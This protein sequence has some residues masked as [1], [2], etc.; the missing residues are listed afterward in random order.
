MALLMKY[1]FALNLAVIIL[2]FCV[3]GFQIYRWNE[4]IGSIVSILI[5][6]IGYIPAVFGGRGKESGWFLGTYVLLL[7]ADLVFQSV[8]VIRL[9]YFQ[10]IV[11]QYCIHLNVSVDISEYE[12]VACNDWWHFGKLAVNLASW[13]NISAHVTQST[14][15][16]MT[17]IA[18]FHRQQ[19]VTAKSITEIGH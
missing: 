16:R 5:S 15:N 4:I 17:F 12:G 3:L 10:W 18:F 1:V 19:Q 7:T 8:N 13:K 6:L 9:I 11:I 2:Q 14:N